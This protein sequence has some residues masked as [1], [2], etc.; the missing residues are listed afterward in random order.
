MQ[1]SSCL[2]DFQLPSSESQSFSPELRS[3][4]QVGK[5]LRAMQPDRKVVTGP[6]SGGHEVALEGKA[7]VEPREGWGELVGSLEH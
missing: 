5:V 6:Q 2:C 3:G 7:A 1:I 4:L